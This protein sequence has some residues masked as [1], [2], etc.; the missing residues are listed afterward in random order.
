[1]P[2]GAA[3]QHVIGKCEEVVD[4]GRGVEDLVLDR[5]RIEGW[6]ANVLFRV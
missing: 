5:E 4:I 2:Y 6:E 3:Q 1:M